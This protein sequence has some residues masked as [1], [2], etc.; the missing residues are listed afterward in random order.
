MGILEDQNKRSCA[1]DRFEIAGERAKHFTFE[2][3]PVQRADLLGGLSF[4]SDAEE[5]EQVREDVLGLS[6]K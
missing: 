5:M 3:F 1:R 6:A 2:R 4:K